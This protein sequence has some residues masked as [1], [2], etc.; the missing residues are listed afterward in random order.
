MEQFGVR[1]EY[2]NAAHLEALRLLYKTLKHDKEAQIHRD[3][4]DWFSAIPIELGNNF[5]WPDELTLADLKHQ[6]ESCPKWIP[7]PAE[8]LSAKWDFYS[9]VDSIHSGDYTVLGLERLDDSIAELQIDPHGYPY[10]G[11]GPLMALVEGFGFTLLGV[12]EYGKYLTRE[13]LL[14]R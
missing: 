1:F 14:P 9:L 8:Q 2:G 5:D 13:E 11:V 4:S 7:E 10:G 3:L 12:N 6:R